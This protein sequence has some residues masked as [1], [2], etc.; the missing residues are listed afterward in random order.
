MSWHG[1]KQRTF[2]VHPGMS[3]HTCATLLGEASR[4]TAVRMPQRRCIMTC[5]RT[6]PTLRQA[7]AWVQL[8]N[9]LGRLLQHPDRIHSRGFITL[10]VAQAAR[11]VL[12]TGVVAGLK[13]GP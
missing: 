4:Q 7:A 3:N 8:V 12:N 13:F 11:C 5:S 6:S 10:F 2:D 1:R 9:A